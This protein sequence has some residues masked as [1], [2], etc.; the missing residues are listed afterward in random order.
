MAKP[1]LKGLIAFSVTFAVLMMPL[2]SSLNSN[3]AGAP[4]PGFSFEINA[5]IQLAAFSSYDQPWKAYTSCALYSSGPANSSDTIMNV[6]VGLEPANLSELNYFL[7]EL[8]NSVSGMYHHYLTLK[9]FIAGYSPPAAVYDYLVKYYREAGINTVTTFSD[10]M[11]ISLSGTPNEIG[12]AFNTTI[13][14]YQSGKYV[15]YGPSSTPYMPSAVLKYVSQ[16]SGL[17]DF[18]KYIIGTEMGAVKSSGGYSTAGSYDGYPSPATYNGIQ[19]IYGS[20]L[21]VAYQEQSLFA[22]YGYPTDQQEATILW[23]GVYSGSSTINSPYGSITPGEQVGPFV[24]SDIYAYYNET[25]PVGEPHSTIIPVPLNGAP[26]PGPKAAYCTS[27][28][29]ENTLDLEMLGTSAPGSTIYNVYSGTPS[30]AGLDQA[31]SYIL[32]NL[33]NVKVI[34]NS[35]GS[36]EQNDSTWYNDLMEAQ[37]L[38]VSVLVASGDSGDSPQSPKYVGS[39]LWYPASMA[40]N[41]FGD[42]AVGGTTLKLTSALS[43][44]NQT[45]WYIAATASSGPYGTT[46]GISTLFREPSW[47]LSSSANALISGSGRGVPD[48]SAIGNNT[49]ITISIGDQSGYATYYATNASSGDPFYYVFGTSVSSPVDAGIFAAI[50]HVLLKERRGT[51]GFADPQIYS[52]GTQ[53]YSS[54]PAQG[55]LPFTP[56]LY[57]HNNYYSDGYGYTLLNGWGTLNAYNFT[58]FFLQTYTVTFTE[59]GLSRG[60]EWTVTINGESYHSTATNLTIEFTNGTYTFSASASGYTESSNSSSFI[61]NGSNVTVNEITF[62]AIQ[63]SSLP[64]AFIVVGVIVLAIVL[65]LAYMVIGGKSSGKS[66]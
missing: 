37:A 9:E 63:Q 44:E 60:T 19:L 62:K 58:T 50:N 45:N 10:R 23:S 59:S 27:A 3:N 29:L 53:E 17:S 34:S 15:F 65:I 48:I 57:G 42:I 7:A 22:Q 64:V 14:D 52:L 4:I 51:L 25:L 47:Q 32:N 55:I 33:A 16:V 26:L 66:P 20:E 40:Y 8:S 2:S 24:P 46:S 39:E 18:S 30:L 36:K 35:W 41:S 54:K 13:L 43:I 21:Q 49:L 38:G 6:V 12:R 5:P 1:G 61:V 56:I 28:S 31:F 11:I